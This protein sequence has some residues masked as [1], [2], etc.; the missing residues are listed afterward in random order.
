MASIKTQQ[1]DASVVAFLQQ[2]DTTVQ[3]SC[4]QLLA[5]MRTA[6]GCEPKMWGANIVGFGTY[7]YKYA[8]GHSGDS[9]IVGFSPRKGK[10]SIYVMDGTGRHADLLAKLGKHKIGKACIYI[11]STDHINL[12]VLQQIIKKSYAFTST[13]YS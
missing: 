6:T 9:C 3:P 10:I 5:I 12:S 2:T 7:H 11:N 4:Q 1:T 13:Q 8:S